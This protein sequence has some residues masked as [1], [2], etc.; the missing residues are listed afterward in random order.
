MKIEG[1]FSVVCTATSN[2]IQPHSCRVYL[3]NSFREAKD[4]LMRTFQE[5]LSWDTEDYGSTNV[6]SV[7]DGNWEYARIRIHGNNLT[8]EYHL[9]HHV[10]NTH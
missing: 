4:Y 5:D 3:L 9:S 2:C 6:E 1:T 7:H 8:R 10:C